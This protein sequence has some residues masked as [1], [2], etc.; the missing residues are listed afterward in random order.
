[1]RVVLHVTGEGEHTFSD[2]SRVD[3]LDIVSDA[4]KDQN[5]VRI[6]VIK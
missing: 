4:L 1:V 3:V 5:V 2:M 6:E